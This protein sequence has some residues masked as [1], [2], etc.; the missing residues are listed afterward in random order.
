MPKNR[1]INAKEN[2]M[3]TQTCSQFAASRM[4]PRFQKAGFGLV[5]LSS[6]DSNLQGGAKTELVS[7][8]DLYASYLRS[9]RTG[10]QVKLRSSFRFEAS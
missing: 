10:N 2:P 3:S 4:I 1:S 8:S 7:G 5:R 9:Q 6:C